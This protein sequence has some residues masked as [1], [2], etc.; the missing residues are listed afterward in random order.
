MGNGE[1]EKRQLLIPHYLLKKSNLIRARPFSEG[2]AVVRVNHKFGFID[3][4]G[5]VVIEPQFD[6]ASSFA[7]GMAAVNI[8]GTFSKYSDILSSVDRQ[9]FCKGGK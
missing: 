5:D 7:G 3:R 9:Y 6:C 4:L 8:G 2:L 1:L